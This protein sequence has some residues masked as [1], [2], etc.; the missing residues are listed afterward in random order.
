MQRLWT[1]CRRTESPSYPA[2]RTQSNP[3][4]ANV[5]PFSKPTALNSNRMSLGCRPKSDRRRHPIPRWAA[6]VGWFSK[7]TARHPNRMPLGCR[8]ESDRRRHPISRWAAQVGRVFQ[9]DR[10][11]PES[12]APRHFPHAPPN[13]S[14]LFSPPAAPRRVGRKGGPPKTDECTITGSTQTSWVGAG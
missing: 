13:N 11:P 4:W 2:P 5:G 8:P 6:N 12:H 7:P 10:A 9:T 1:V 14:H 3:R